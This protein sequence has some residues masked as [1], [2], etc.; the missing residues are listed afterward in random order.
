MGQL[1]LYRQSIQKILKYH[2]QLDPK[3]DGVNT[4]YT[5]FAVS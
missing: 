3:V 2:R 5:E 1:M 4:K